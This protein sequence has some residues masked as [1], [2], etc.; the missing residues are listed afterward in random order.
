MADT[1]GHRRARI[2]RAKLAWVVV[3]LVIMILVVDLASR[4]TGRLDSTTSPPSAL[5]VGHLGPAKSFRLPGLAS[6]DRA[7]SLGDARSRPVVVNFWASWCTPCRAEMPMLAAA[8]RHLDGR[9]GFI[10]VDEN[11]DRAGGLGL[12]ARAGTGYPV[13]FD[14]GGAL[15]GP[16]DLM[17]LPTTIFVAPGG[18]IV[19]RALGPLTVGSL[20][21]A[22]ARLGWAE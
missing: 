12:T 2:R 14:P 5:S 16:Y 1:V 7:V 3:A 20:D 10:G 19:A 13:G 9:V 4:A 15:S 6:G 22:L 21:A 11:D 8:A 18:Q 17:G